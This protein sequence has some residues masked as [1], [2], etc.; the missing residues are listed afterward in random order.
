MSQK[1]IDKGI[2]N[3]EYRQKKELGEVGNAT[4][5]VKINIRSVMYVITYTSKVFFVVA[6]FQLELIEH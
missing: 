1:Y 3:Q 6:I 4:S 5:F 2:S